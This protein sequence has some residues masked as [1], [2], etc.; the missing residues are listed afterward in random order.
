MSAVSHINPADKVKQGC[1]PGSALSQDRHKF[2]PP[3]ANRGI[4]KHDVPFSALQVALAEVL[5][6]DEKLLRTF[7]IVIFIWF[8]K[9]VIL[10]INC[11]S[12]V[13]KSTQFLILP[14]AKALRVTHI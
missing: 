14:T 1:F 3:D 10:I 2:T 6:P 9:I 7:L 11:E 4:F 5:Q 13:T 12:I 8:R